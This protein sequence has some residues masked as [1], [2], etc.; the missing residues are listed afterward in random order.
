[1]QEKENTVVVEGKAGLSRKGYGEVLLAGFGM[2][3]IE[4]IPYQSRFE[5]NVVR[6]ED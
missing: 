5:R 3:A 1:M 4:E 6:R 2:M